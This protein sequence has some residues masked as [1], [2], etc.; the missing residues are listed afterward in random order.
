[1]FHLFFLKDQAIL[2]GLS[3]LILYILHSCSIVF[4]QGD[5]DISVWSLPDEC[6]LGCSLFL[7][8]LS[9]FDL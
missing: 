2:A 9:L 4:Q 7:Q 5:Q 1:L 3:L 8:S 6:L